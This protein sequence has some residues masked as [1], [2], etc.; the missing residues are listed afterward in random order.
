MSAH[1]PFTSDVGAP[2]LGFGAAPIG[3]LFRPVTDEEAHDAVEAAWNA[4]IRYFDSAPYYGSGLSECRLGEALA[5]RPRGE[6]LL[7][8]KVGKRLLDE[9]EAAVDGLVDGQWAMPRARRTTRDY[10]R[11]SVLRE[12]EESL[13]RLRCDRIDILY[14]HDPD[15]HLDQ[16]E[17]VTAPALAELRA[18]GVI[19]AFGVGTSDW[20]VADRLV[21]TTELDGVMIAGRWTLVDRSAAPLVEDARAAGVWLVVAGPF[22]S[23]L[24]STPWPDD[25]ARFEY[26]P[27]G[28]ERVAAARELALAC[29]RHGVELPEAA[30]QFAARTEGVVAV[31]AGMASASEV[32]T[33]AAAF[34]RELPASLWSELDAIVGRLF[35][36]PPRGEGSIST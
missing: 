27:A 5:Y 23:G 2:M 13:Q 21:R 28:A 20:R 15:D 16:V 6:F 36:S 9:T 12:V 7:S 3:N 33:D 17:H 34:R 14:L 30:I 26:A 1:P 24:L 31:V 10:S 32:E 11:D 8:T 19:S 35:G 29:R 22:N 4:G 18:Q 25:R